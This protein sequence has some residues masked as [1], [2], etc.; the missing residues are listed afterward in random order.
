MHDGDTVPAGASQT[1]D[2]TMDTQRRL[3]VTLAWLDKGS[4]SADLQEDLDLTVTDPDGQV[5][6]GNNRTGGD[7]I[8]TIEKVG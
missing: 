3:V 8:N 5:W 1:Y 4:L 7:N 6:W 2:V